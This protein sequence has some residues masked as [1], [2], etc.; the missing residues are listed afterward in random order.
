MRDVP[1]RTGRDGTGRE[2]EIIWGNEEK[3]KEGKR[4]EKE[5]KREKREEDNRK[6]GEREVEYFVRNYGQSRGEIFASLT[7]VAWKPTLHAT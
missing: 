4:R 7:G 6:V 5:G 2:R 1:A 3:R